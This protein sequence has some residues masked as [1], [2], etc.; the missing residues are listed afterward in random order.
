MAVQPFCA[1]QVVLVLSLSFI[2]Y[3]IVKMSQKSLGLLF[4]FL[5]GT[6]TLGPL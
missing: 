5:T 1:T 6:E 3:F 4:C 2:I